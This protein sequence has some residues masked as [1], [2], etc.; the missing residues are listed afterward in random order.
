MVRE[1]SLVAFNICGQKQKSEYYYFDFLS[2]VKWVIMSF[3]KNIFPKAF[4]FLF[5]I[6]FIHF[7]AL[8]QACQKLK[9][10]FL[11]TFVVLVSTVTKGQTDTSLILPSL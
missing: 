7:L 5:Q 4:I 3:F 9:E 1:N 2:L 11:K 8:F 6:E 10:F